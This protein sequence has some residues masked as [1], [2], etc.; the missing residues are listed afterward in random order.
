MN[1]SLR[2]RLVVIILTPLLVIAGIIAS[3]AVYLGSDESA[4]VTGQESVIDGGMTL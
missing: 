1:T 4:Y 3:L 2:L